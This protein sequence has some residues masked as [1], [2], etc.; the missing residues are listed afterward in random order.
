VR[1]PVLKAL[2]A[3]VCLTIGSVG[4]IPIAYVYP[5]VDYQSVS[6]LPSHEADI[7]TQPEITA[8]LL[9][10]TTHGG[11]IPLYRT[12]ATISTI[13]LSNEGDAKH[14]R[15]TLESGAFLL[16]AALSHGWS[17]S[18]HARLRLYRPGFKTIEID[19]Q[20]ADEK[21][22]WIPVNNAAEYEDAIDQV[23]SAGQRDIKEIV[24]LDRK[25]PFGMMFSVY[26]KG[27]PQTMSRIAA[28]Y[29]RL[30]NL[31]REH[32]IPVRSESFLSHD[33]LNDVKQELSEM[34]SKSDLTDDDRSRLESLHADLDFETRWADP[35]S[36]LKAKIEWLESKAGSTD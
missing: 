10:T 14:L 16:M 26:Y 27:E 3:T 15:V 28:E 11:L 5:K 36:R 6:G 2:L 12:E 17:T 33:S 13:P 23:L 35:V 18:H 19:K 1:I 8:Y 25:N 32:R 9:R 20:E 29:S 24:Q 31:I 4:C 22:D 7:D 34:S 21:L 30:L